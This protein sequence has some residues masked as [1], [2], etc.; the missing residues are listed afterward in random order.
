MIDLKEELRFLKEIDE[1]IITLSANVGL[2]VGGK[3]SKILIDLFNKNVELLKL[4]L[5]KY[6]EDI[7]WFIYECEFGDKPKIVEVNS[8]EYYI[9]SISEFILYIK[10]TIWGL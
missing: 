9:D 6:A 8:I 2:D 3:L 5:N 4:I 7:D 10:A 1:K